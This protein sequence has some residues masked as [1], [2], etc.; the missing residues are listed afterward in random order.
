MSVSIQRTLGHA[1][2]VCYAILV[3]LG[4]AQAVKRTDYVPLGR[5]T[6]FM[7]GM[8]APYQGHSVTTEAFLA[9]GF[10]GN[11]W[12]T[13]DLAPYY[14]VIIGER[15]MREWHVYHNWAQYESD[16]AVHRAYATKLR[17]LEAVAGRQ[18]EQVR[19]SWIQWMPTE[20]DYRGPSKNPIQRVS[21]ITIP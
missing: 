8:L 18:Y 5:I 10:D 16:E 3:A 7:Y 21:L 4:T 2:I 6:I 11:E 13:I 14:P 20:T 19:L 9:E 15:S 12:R 1:L 17:D